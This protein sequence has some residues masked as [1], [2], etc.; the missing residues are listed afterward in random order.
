MVL[1]GSVPAGKLLLWLLIVLLMSFA[2][3]ACS[4]WIDQRKAAKA[5]RR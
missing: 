3:S 1:S 5:A 2:G 4:D